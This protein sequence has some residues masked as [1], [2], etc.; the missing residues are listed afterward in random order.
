MLTRTGPNPWRVAI[1]LEELG[2]PH[3]TEF[4]DNQK[5][6]AKPFTDINPNGRVPAIED[7]NTGTTLW[8]SGAIVQYLVETYDK[9]NKISFPTS[10]PDRFQTMQWLFFQATGQ[11][12]YFGQAAWFHKFH[13]EQ[14]PSAKERYKNE[15]DRVTMVLN[16]ALEGKK[17]LVGNK[18]TFADLS[19]IMWYSMLGFIFGD[20]SPDL[21]KK[22]P[23]FG[24]WL[25]SMQ[26]RASVKK[27]FEDKAKAASH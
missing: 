10:S 13:P 23:N 8:E 17:Y 7:P 15:V 22:Y 1:I 16:N 24:F 25:D 27:V 20:E 19:F 11:G 5:V 3:E 18:C 12:P 9:E 26:A 2:L 4:M 6:K 21:H 14:L